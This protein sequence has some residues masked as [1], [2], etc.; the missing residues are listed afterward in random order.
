MAQ[1]GSVLSFD[2]SLSEDMDILND[3]HFEALLRICSS[4]C[5]AYGAAAPTCSSNRLSEDNSNMQHTLETLKRCVT[6]LRLIF[7]AGGHV[8][9]EQAPDAISW[10]EHAV[11]SFLSLTS[12]SC[13]AVAACHYDRTCEQFWLFASSFAS[14]QSLAC[15]CPHEQQRGA[16]TRHNGKEEFFLEQNAVGHPYPAAL[17]TAFA[18]L[19]CP[20]LDVSGGHDISFDQAPLWLPVK[21]AHAPPFSS[22]DGGGLFSSPD[23]SSPSRTA[24]DCFR[25][26]RQS[27]MQRIMSSRLDKMLIAHFL[28]HDPS[29]PFD[30]TILH[31]FRCDLEAFLNQHSQPV[32]WEIRE[33]QPMHLSI[34]EALHTIQNDPDQALFPALKNGVSTGFLGDIE[35]SGCFP[36]NDKEGPMDTP[37]S[38][39][40]GNWQSA[41]DDLNLTRSLV[42]AEVDNG[43]VFKYTGDL[44]SAQV[45]F[46][47]GVSIGKLGVAHS[48]SRPPRLVVD[49]T[50]CGLNARCRIPERSTLPSAKDVLRCFPLRESQANLMGLSLDVKAA[51]KRVVLR[52]SEWGLVG[53]SLDNE[54][55][56]YKVTPFGGVFSAAWWSRLGGWMLRCFH[57]LLWLSHTGLLYVD[58][59]LFFQDAQIMPV[60]AALLCIFCQLTKI[61]ISWGKCELGGSICWIGWIFHISAGFLEI[62]NDKITKL[63][64]YLVDLQRSSKTTR[65]VLEKF[66]GLCMWITQLFPYMRIW[67]HYLYRD[68]Q[69]IPATHFSIDPGDWPILPQCLTETLTFHSRPSGT[70]IPVGGKLISVRHQPVQCLED[71]R[72]LRLSERRIWMRIRDPSST[73][74]SLSDDSQRISAIFAQWVHHHSPLRPLR[75]KAYWSG[76]AAAD[77]CASGSSCQIGGFIHHSSGAIFCFAEKFASHDFDSFHVGL[78]SDLQRNITCFETLAQMALIW[79]TSRTFPGHRLPICLRSVSDNTGAEAGSNKLFTM[80]R[81]LCFFLERLCLLAASVS[82]EIDVSHIS[83][84]SN[85]H[86]DALSRW[87]FHDPPPHGFLPEAR[88]RLSLNDLWFRPRKVSLHPPQAQISWPLPK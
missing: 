14:L 56:F 52:Q 49:S 21:P 82:I 30:E 57:R 77:A 69:N 32:S 63:K 11:S 45:D 7:L 2:I 85:T 73:R 80:A 48:D 20:L 31:P 4:G 40:W 86:A 84:P 87:D 23:W 37:L 36:V 13:I 54:L 29:A 88:L 5:V 68:L 71:L 28:K 43:W 62:P 70:A 55:Y 27:W 79:T 83:G 26:L 76:H 10:W 72:V 67:L 12:A 39:H 1:G 74:R 50:I 17:A 58:D 3:L 15:I 34:L 24:E 46:P 64:K 8:H 9:L 18:H 35:P 81:P 75:P 59:F 6:C 65:K 16:R 22:E 47:A 25:M 53:F 61:P 66:I 33:H 60:S 19:T 51:H 78:D 38:A 42:Q 44:A 41:E